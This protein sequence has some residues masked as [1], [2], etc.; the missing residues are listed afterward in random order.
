MIYGL[1]YMSILFSHIPCLYYTIGQINME[2][3]LQTDFES[4]HKKLAFDMCLY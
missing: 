1:L 2:K 4:R 3:Y